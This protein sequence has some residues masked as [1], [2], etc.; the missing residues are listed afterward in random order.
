[1]VWD[2]QFIYNYFRI[3]SDQRLLLGGGNIFSTYANKETHNYSRI[4][5]KFTDYFASYFPELKLQF[6]YQ[7][8]GLIGLSKNI[9]HR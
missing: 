7:W 1:M 6:E 8:P 2:T 9:L 5:R 4:T 3:T